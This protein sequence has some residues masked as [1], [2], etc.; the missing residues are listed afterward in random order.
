MSLPHPTTGRCQTRAD[1][2]AALLLAAGSPS[3]L[4]VGT[5][6]HDRRP[7][8]MLVVERCPCTRADVLLVVEGVMAAVPDRR[9]DAMVLATHGEILGAHAELEMWRGMA[10]R[11]SL[12]GVAL[13]DWLVIDGDGAC[14]VPA[15]W[16]ELPVW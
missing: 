8:V 11:C 6:D 16:D 5:L 12:A 7:L 15:L 10:R 3:T 2:H 9:F 4:A 14:S 1:A 13:L